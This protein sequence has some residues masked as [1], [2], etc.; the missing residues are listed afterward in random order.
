MKKLIYTTFIVIQGIAMNAFAQDD[1]YGTIDKNT[2]AANLS[3]D[4]YQ[5]M[6]RT[7]YVRMTPKQK[8]MAIQSLNAYNKVAKFKLTPSGDVAKIDVTELESYMEQSEVLLGSEIT[9]PVMAYEMDKDDIGYKSYMMTLDGE[10]KSKSFS[11]EDKFIAFAR[12]P[13]VLIKGKHPYTEPEPLPVWSNMPA[14]PVK[15]QPA[16]TVFIPK[17]PDTVVKEV[18]KTEGTPYIVNNIYNITP[19]GDA[20]NAGVVSRT[21]GSTAGVG[22]NYWGNSSKFGDNNC[23]NNGNWNNGGGHASA[24]VSLNIVWYLSNPYYWEDNY[25]WCARTRTRVP[26]DVY[27]SLCSN[28]GNPGVSQAVPHTSNFGS[29][30]NANATQQVVTTVYGHR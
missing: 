26:S 22:G 6:I 30:N 4:V 29:T 2:L 19:G 13:Y 7:T 25:W 15:Q 27:G 1:T 16:P 8:V 23:W 11:R 14:A 3:K 17:Q 28:F 21:Y 10:D 18:T 12:I 5:R 24:G 9:G 20:A